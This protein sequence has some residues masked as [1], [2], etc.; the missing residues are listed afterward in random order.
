LINPLP[1]DANAA[2][3]LVAVV[4]KSFLE[5]GFLQFGTDHRLPDISANIH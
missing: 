2:M 4:L 5:R 3:R 1:V